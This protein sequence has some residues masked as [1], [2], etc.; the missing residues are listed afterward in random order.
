MRLTL[1]LSLYPSLISGVLFTRLPT[2]QLA[3]SLPNQRTLYF[4]ALPRITL[5]G[6]YK[7]TTPRVE[8]VPTK[9]GIIDRGLN[10]DSR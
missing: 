6:V 7:L 4:T 2:Y 8:G 9:R 1:P 3:S 10:A 5:V